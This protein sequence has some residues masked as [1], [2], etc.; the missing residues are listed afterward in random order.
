MYQAGTSQAAIARHFGVSPLPIVRLLKRRGVKTRVG[1]P[2]RQLTEDQL[3]E[4]KA[5]Y[6]GGVSQIDIARRF[7]TSQTV[8]S[9]TLRA[10]GMSTQRKWLQ[11][12]ERHG[13][14]KGGVINVGGY[15]TIHITPDHPMCGMAHHSGYVMEHRLVM[16]E[17]LGRPLTSR[18]TVHHINGNKLDNR[19]ENLQLRLGGHGKGQALCCAD[20]G[21][22]NVVPC[23]LD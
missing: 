1:R 14:W 10:E 16:A 18:E 13:R 15:R 6:A 22:R 21:S 8:V 23:P 17:H 7:G 3:A 5:L 12:G 4:M 20:C 2:Q 11:R 19:L 9:R